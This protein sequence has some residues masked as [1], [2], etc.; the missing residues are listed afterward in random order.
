MQ[1]TEEQ[2]MIRESADR[3]V[4]SHCDFDARRKRARTDDAYDAELWAMM[5]EL[6]WP[7]LAFSEEEGGAGGRVLDLFPIYE[8]FGRGLVL[9]PFFAS[10]SLAGGFVRHATHAERKEETIAGLLAG[11]KLASAALMEPRRRYD[12]MACDTVAEARSGGYAIS[13]VKTLCLAGADANDIVVLARTGGATGE[14]GGRTLFLVPAG[15]NGVS[16]RGYRMRDD[17]R[18]ADITFDSVEVGPEAVIGE[19]GGATAILDTVLAT[20]R[21]SLAAE[22]LGIMDAALHAVKDYGMQRKQFGRPIASFQVLTHRI[23][24]MFV[25]DE[26]SRSLI[27]QAAMAEGTDGFGELCRQAK[28]KANV[29]GQHVLKEAIQLHGAIG[30]TEELIIGHYF[31][32]MMTISMLLDDSHTLR[33]AA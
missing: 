33:Q 22:A 24:D 32:R 8:A 4:K 29:A 13:G 10:L 16:R 26:E 20:A 28:L 19:V 17:H 31:R 21:L 7:M 9:E 12:L 25:H 15:A 14:A 11:E 5:T 1:L 23:T 2:K 18:A 30:V 27:Y 3:F 6:G